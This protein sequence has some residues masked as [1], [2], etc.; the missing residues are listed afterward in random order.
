MQKFY[1]DPIYSNMPFYT[2][3]VA[4]NRPTP[5]DKVYRWRSGYALQG[6]GRLRESFAD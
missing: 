6:A 3:N 1:T 2:V 5:A 4:R